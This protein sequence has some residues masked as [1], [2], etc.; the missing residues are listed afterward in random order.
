MKQLYQWGINLVGGTAGYFAGDAVVKHK[1]EWITKLAKSWLDR[2]GHEHI[3][4]EQ[5]DAQRKWI[6]RGGGVFLGLVVSGIILAYEHWV[7]QESSRIAVGEI[8]NDIA[9]LKVLQKTDPELLKENQKLQEMLV[10]EEQKTAQLTGQPVAAAQAT[11]PVAAEAPPGVKVQSF[12]QRGMVDEPSQ[13]TTL[14]HG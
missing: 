14:A 10:A 9:N 5:V 11:P 1:P 7:K 3:T 6:G 8:N 2:N 13:A 4:A 12:E